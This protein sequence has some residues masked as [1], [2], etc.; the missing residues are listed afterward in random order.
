MKK[1]DFLDKVAGAFLQLYPRWEMLREDRRAYKRYLGLNVRNSCLVYIDFSCRP[2]SMNAYH[3]VGWSTDKARFV[4]DIT[5]DVRLPKP[6]D[7]SLR[8]LLRLDKP[9]DFAYDDMDVS[10]SLLHKPFDGFDLAK[11]PAE[12]VQATMLQ[13]IEDFAFPYLCMMLKHRHQLDVAPAQLGSGV[14]GS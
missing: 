8:R 14:F 7:G 9:R 1:N 5:Q 2:D 3:G 6:R 12:T 10:I 13:E 4:N 11:E